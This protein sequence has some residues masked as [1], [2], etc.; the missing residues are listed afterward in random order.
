MPCLRAREPAL[1]KLAVFVFPTA[2]GH[3]LVS[4]SRAEGSMFDEDRHTFT[5]TAIHSRTPAWSPCAL[6][7]VRQS[8]ENIRPLRIVPAV[9]VMCLQT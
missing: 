2:F 3:V 7:G 6:R 5:C 4:F 8:A 1:E 9:R